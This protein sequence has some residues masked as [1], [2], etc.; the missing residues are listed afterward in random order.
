LNVIK[1]LYIFA[2]HVSTWV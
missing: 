2:H 1:V